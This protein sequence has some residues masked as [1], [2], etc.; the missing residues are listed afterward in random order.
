MVCSRAAAAPIDVL[1]ACAVNASPEASGIEALGEACPELSKALESLG[2]AP[3]LYDGWR[4]QLNRD[5]LR[6]LANLAQNYS[7]P[8]PG[9]SPDI[10]LVPGIVKALAREQVSVRISWWEAF[11]TWLKTWLANHLD[12]TSWFERIRRSATL[13]RLMAYGLVA[14]LSAAAAFVIWTQWRSGGLMRRR[15][16]AASAAS[17]PADSGVCTEPGFA[18]GPTELLRAIVDCLMQSGRLRTERSLTHR[19]LVARGV[20]DDDSQRAVFA[21]V[22]GAAESTLYG[23]RGEPPQ[24]ASALLEDGRALLAQLSRS[25]SAR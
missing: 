19:E 8:K 23:P 13:F 7:R 25:A 11:G 2:L 10:A 3:M 1:R 5:A 9:D 21:A 15:P 17:P 12:I 24:R 20:F 18:A 14:L 6:D 4:G 22:A 16:P